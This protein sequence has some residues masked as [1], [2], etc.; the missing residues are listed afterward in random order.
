MARLKVIILAASLAV[1][2]ALLGALY[3]VW[4]ED[5]ERRTERLLFARAALL[6]EMAFGVDSAVREEMEETAALAC[7][8]DIAAVL[9]GGTEAGGGHGA[10]PSASAAMDR[11]AASFSAICRV[12]PRWTEIA[13]LDASG[14]EILAVARGGRGGD[15]ASPRPIPRNALAD[16]S[17]E[18]WF[19]GGMGVGKRRCFASRIAPA[20]EKGRIEY[21]VRPVVRFASPVIRPEAGGRAAPT[22][23]VA[24]EVSGEWLLKSIYSPDGTETFLVDPE[25]DFLVHP[26]RD[27][28]WGREIAAQT[29]APRISFQM[30]YPGEWEKLIA[31]ERDIGWTDLAVLISRP[32]V[33][34]NRELR[35]ICRIPRASLDVGTSTLSFLAAALALQVL[36]STAGLMWISRREAAERKRAEDMAELRAMAEERNRALEEA[37]RATEEASRAKSRF[38]ASVSHELRTPLTS[39]I[40]FAEILRDYPDLGEADRRGMIHTI[41][42][43]SHHLLSLVNAVLDLAKIEAGKVSVK[44]SA[45]PVRKFSEVCAA[46]IKGAADKRKVRVSCDASGA[47]EWA[48]LDERHAREIL[49]NLMG[50]AVKFTEAGG[51]VTLLVDM[52]DP[53]RLRFR[54]SDTGCGIPPEKLKDLFRPFVQV[55]EAQKGRPQGTGL[56]LAISRDLAIRMG[57]ELFA[58]SEPGKGSTFTLILPY[59]EPPEEEKR[60]DGEKK[61]VPPEPLEASIAVFDDDENIRKLISM[62]LRLWGCKV[63]EFPDASHLAGAMVDSPDAVI[64]DINMPEGGGIELARRLRAAAS[65]AGNGRCAGG[66]GAGEGRGRIPVIACTASVLEHQVAELAATGLF[67]DIIPKPVDWAR[68]YSAVKAAGSKRKAAS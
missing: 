62:H 64:C 11:L 41:V 6:R 46:T 2:A 34:G 54:V 18:E 45:V 7:D 28:C 56:G 32:I 65:A 53:H 61:F 12:K 44:L 40:G 36:L 30:L 4:R 17:K 10:S 39:I 13:L 51:S 1:T 29:G 48:M 25:G 67:A 63:R 26:D 43:S 50:N 3:K 22:G 21:P 38:L 57:G 14:R 31:A 66:D 60:T 52:P 27:M 55:E 8:P 47:P 9:T 19:A 16:R 68:L 23:M 5:R 33:I 58:E 37:R 15:P 35:L 42:E 20:K 24:V 59:I 49:F